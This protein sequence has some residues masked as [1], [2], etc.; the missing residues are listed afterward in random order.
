MVLTEQESKIKFIQSVLPM[1]ERL[2]QLA[3]E[4]SELAQAALK[5]RRAITGI[6]PTP[7]SKEEAAFSALEELADVLIAAQACG[8]INEIIADR[9][10]D[11]YTTEKAERWAN[12]LKGKGD[13]RI[14]KNCEYYADY[15]GVCCN[16]CFVAEYD[17]CVMWEKKKDEP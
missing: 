4:A 17:T 6:N 1:E 10:I 3:E 2:A 9:Y 14:C 12:R 15:E 7:I 5:L 16:G 13:Y 11:K 8:L